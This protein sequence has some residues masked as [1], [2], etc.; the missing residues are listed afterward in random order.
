MS[1]LAG[2]APALRRGRRRGARSGWVVRIAVVT[3]G[4]LAFVALAAPLLAPHDPTTLD[5][6]HTLAGPSGAHPLGTDASGRD[7]L[8]RLM[9]GARPSLIGPL[10]VVLLATAASTVLGVA[11]AWAGGWVDGV[12]ARGLDVVFSF[13]GI[14]LAILAVALFGR[15]LGAPVAALAI[16]YTPYIAR[17]TRAAALRERRQPYI[18]ACELQG[19]SPLRIC[20][21]HLLPNIAPVLL[22]QSSLAFGYAMVDLAAIS[23]LGFGVQPPTADWG[24]MVGAGQSSLLKG[25]PQETLFAGALIAIAVVSVTVLGQRVGRSPASEERA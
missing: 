20:G 18:A 4:L 25:Y 13:P 12:I 1:V 17:V 2:R 24:S 21:R 16:A 8:S 10:A 14:L 3:L 15:G 6:S 11:A 9:Y 22:A 5:L 23:F 7:L 19:L